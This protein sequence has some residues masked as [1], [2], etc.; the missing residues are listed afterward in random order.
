MSSE[1]TKWRIQ[2]RANRKAKWKNVSGLYETRE[3]AR[4]WQRGTRKAFGFGN[5]RI[6]KHVRGEK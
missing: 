3:T 6:V 2:A 4:W 1:K 5:T